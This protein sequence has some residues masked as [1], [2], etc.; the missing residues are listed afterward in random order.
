M[1]E[2][3]QDRP[4][5][6]SLGAFGDLPA[7]GSPAHARAVQRVKD[8]LSAQ[9]A[10]L[11]GAVEALRGLV[12]QHDPLQLLPAISMLTSSATW[13]KGGRVDDGDQTFSWDA[14]IEYLAGLVLAGPV[15][16]AAVGEKATRKAIELTAAVFDATQA[17]LFLSS[18]EEDVNRQ[19]GPRS[20]EVHD[21]GGG[22]G[23]PDARLCRL[24]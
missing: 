11:D 17:G 4:L 20:Y 10:Q 24:P 23:R 16:E 14:K 12:A 9:A 1:L 22:S 13:T 8:D 18:V 6:P 19:P 5:G 3:P 7:A 2:F 15:G 21:A